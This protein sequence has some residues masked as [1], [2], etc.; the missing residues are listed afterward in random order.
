MSKLVHNGAALSCSEGMGPGTLVVPPL[1]LTVGES[2]PLATVQD[3]I[4]F[5]NI[6]AFPLCKS[7]ANP[8]V[9]AATAA[10]MGVLTPQPCV[11]CPAGPW[12]PGASGV[13]INGIAA[14]DE[15]SSCACL[16]A[17]KIEVVLSGVTAIAAG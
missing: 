2:Q 5:V 9:I 4:P 14:L 16:W 3:F 10:A 8:Q 12:S 6:A 13:T 17:G 15:R 1:N 7:M 11:P